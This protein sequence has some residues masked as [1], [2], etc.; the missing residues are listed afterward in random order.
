MKYL[1]SE[2]QYRFLAEQQVQGKVYTNE[3][4][5]KKALSKYNKDLLVYNWLKELQDFSKE[6]SNPNMSVYNYEGVISKK[7]YGS[8]ISKTF[9]Q[10]S[11]AQILE[12][13]SHLFNAW[14]KNKN[15]VKGDDVK[16]A[17]EIYK[18][19]GLDMSKREGKFPILV[20]Q[21]KT[22]QLPIYPKP[23]KPIFKPTTPK[24]IVNT[25]IDK[26]KPEVLKPQ[27]S[28]PP[29][30]QSPKPEG[31]SVYGPGYHLIGTIKDKTFIPISDET[32]E[33]WAPNSPYTKIDSELLKDKNKLNQYLRVK[34]GGYLNPVK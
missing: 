12:G 5:Y 1:V 13:L 8:K 7:P 32:I 4:E 20:F 33:T 29:K 25:I 11:I 3:T 14:G 21:G 31:E 34:F 15:Q 19:L 17:R 18:L 30:K 24:P 6:F 16:K 26:P 23:E 10:H 22:F 9:P 28:L 2:T 27:E